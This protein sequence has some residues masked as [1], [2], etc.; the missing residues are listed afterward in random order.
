MKVCPKTL[1]SKIIPPRRF[2]QLTLQR[3]N[4]VQEEEQE[5]YVKLAREECKLET[6]RIKDKLA[7]ARVKVSERDL[8]EEVRL[9]M[10]EKLER[11]RRSA[12]KQSNQ[13][14][15]IKLRNLLTEAGKPV[16][17]TIQS[18]GTSS[19]TL[20]KSGLV[21]NLTVVLESSDVNVS[22]LDH[23]PNSNFAHSTPAQ[24]RSCSVQGNGLT[25]AV[26]LLGVISD[27]GVER[28]E[29]E[30]S[31]SD[32]GEQSHSRKSNRRKFVRRGRFRNLTRKIMRRKV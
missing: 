5:R 25:R 31:L 18:A 11:A 9:V 4:K 13:G 20:L 1:R 32:V 27:S 21:S 19:L 26:S 6:V 12:L 28:D 16:P 30:S 10:E 7:L 15:K 2:N 8:S 3:W 17:P 14:H 22:S 23:F 24:P 29:E